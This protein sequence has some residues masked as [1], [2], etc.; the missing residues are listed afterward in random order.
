MTQWN[1]RAIQLLHSVQVSDGLK[2]KRDL[3][4]FYGA[5]HCIENTSLLKGKM[6]GKIETLHLKTKAQNK[7][8][9]N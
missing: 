1:N 9:N 5:E 6:A 7:Q 8:T 4:A 3:L 2:E